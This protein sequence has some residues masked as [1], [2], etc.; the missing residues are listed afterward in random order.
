[1]KPIKFKPI[2]KPKIWG[3]GRIA[4]FKNIVSDQDY[5]GEST[6]GIGESWELS[7][8]KGDESVAVG[9]EYDGMTLSGLVARFKGELVGKRVY[10]RF[11]SEFPLLIKL[12]D[13]RSDLSIQVHPGDEM[14]RRLYGRN[15][16]TE[17]WYVIGA[18]DDTHLK[19]GFSRRMTPEEYE[20]RVEEHTIADALADY[21]LQSGDVFFLP[22]GRVH[23]IGAGAFIAEIQ[24]TSD[25]TYRIYDY[26]RKDADGRQRELHTALAKEAI[27]Y[28]GGAD[29]R[30]RCRRERNRE[31][32]LVSCPH[33]TTS[34]LDLDRPYVKAVAAAGSFLTVMCVGGGGTITADGGEATPFT[35]GE[36]LLV[37]ASVKEV[38][39]A[40]E[41]H[42]SV[43]ASRL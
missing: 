28:S 16:K 24:Q 37:P 8:V 31:C 30:L 11:G 38:A 4:A 42:L 34:L 17:M 15:G 6:G 26:G 27:D 13:A 12:I 40:P 7:G 3:G 22:A 43:L 33:F 23:A 9:G 2:F 36:T 18:D 20:C 35:R 25:I 39:F 14:A 1:M 5:T 10:E 41:R 21:K 29:C 32:E 19:C